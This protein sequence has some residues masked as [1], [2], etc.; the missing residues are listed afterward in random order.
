MRRR[1]FTAKSKSAA[2][3]DMPRNE[4]QLRLMLPIEAYIAQFSDKDIS[5]SVH[6]LETSAEINI[7]AD[8]SYYPAS[9]IKI[10]LMM[11]IFRQARGGRFSLDDCLTIVNSFPSV[12]D[13]SLYSL[14]ANDDSDASLYERIGQTES[15]RELTRLMIAH[16][17]NLATNILFEKVGA[18]QINEFIAEL[19][20]QDVAFIRGMYDLPALKKRIYNCGSARGLT[21]TMRLIAEGRVVSKQDSDEMIKI[22]LG[23]KFNAGIPRLLP[24]QTRVAHKTGWSDEYYHDSGIVFPENRK[25]YAVSIM[26]RGFAEDRADEAHEC[27]AHISALVYEQ[28]TFQPSR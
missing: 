8:E 13:G 19:E 17:S 25:P 4:V 12:A 18:K 9:T 28:L 16:S 27:I 15:I 26:T 23:Q 22:L 2:Q 7:R 3:N 20:I 1:F 11:E 14:N 21:Q 10:H 6:D 5:L 24:P